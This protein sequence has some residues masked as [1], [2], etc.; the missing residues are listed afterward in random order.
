M[1]VYLICLP[2]NI[3]V[4]TSTSKARPVPFDPPSGSKPPEINA[5]FGS[6]IGF[7]SASCTHPSGI[8]APAR[9]ASSIYAKTF[10]R[11]LYGTKNRSNQPFLWQ[12]LW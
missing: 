9:R 6:V 7:P 10:Y 8:F 3:P 4:K 2:P 5:I 1:I 11:T 12:Q